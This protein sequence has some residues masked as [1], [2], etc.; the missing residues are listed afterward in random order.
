MQKG[1]YSKTGKLSL[2]L[3]EYNSSSEFLA[4]KDYVINIVRQYDPHIIGV[5]AGET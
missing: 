5:Q 2:E 4:Q 1:Q 3:A